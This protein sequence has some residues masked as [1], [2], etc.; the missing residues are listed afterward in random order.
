MLLPSEEM[1]PS[2]NNRQGNDS[3]ADNPDEAGRHYVV[4]Y[5]VCSCFSRVPYLTETLDQTKAKF[6][7]D[8]RVRLTDGRDPGPYLVAEVTGTLHA[9]A[10]KLCFENG[11]EA[12]NGEEIAE[13][14]LAKA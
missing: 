9:R 4:K 10:Y 8:Q 3:S 12:W 7:R 13:D 2:E 14:H 1:Q 5:K 11:D 6:R